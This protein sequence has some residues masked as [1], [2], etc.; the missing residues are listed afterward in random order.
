[1]KGV[2]M[3]KQRLS[4]FHLRCINLALPCIRGAC[5]AEEDRADAIRNR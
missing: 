5:I 3:I 2:R 1:M 4:P